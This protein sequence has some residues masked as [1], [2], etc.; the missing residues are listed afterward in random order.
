MTAYCSAHGLGSARKIAEAT[1]G[2]LTHEDVRRMKDAEKYGLSQWRILDAALD[3][4]EEK[5]K[6]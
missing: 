2:V 1:N 4:L 3:W 5:N 6:K